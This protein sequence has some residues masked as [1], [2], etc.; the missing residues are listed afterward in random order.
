[1]VERVRAQ[2]SGGAVGTSCLYRLTPRG[3]ADLVLLEQDELT[4][5]STWHAAGNCPTFCTGRGVLQPQQ[6]SRAPA[7]L[8][9]ALSVIR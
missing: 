5:A 6:S 4:S 3:R 9:A 7:G 1:M 2:V 8:S